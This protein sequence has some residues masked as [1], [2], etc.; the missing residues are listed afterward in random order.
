MHDSSEGE[1]HGSENHRRNRRGH[2]G[3]RHRLRRCVRRIP[4]DSR[5]HVA[6]HARAGLAYI[7]TSLDEGVT[8]GKVTAEQRDRALRATRFR[9][10]SWK[11]PAARRIWSSKPFPK[12]WKS[13]SK[14]SRCSINSRSR[15]DFRQSN[16]SSF[17]ITEMAA[18][19]CRPEKCIGLHFFNPVPKMKLLEVVRG[20]ETS[21]ETVA[22]CREV[23][24]PDGQRSCGGARS[25]R[26]HHQPHQR[27]DRQR[28]VLHARR[29]GS[30]PPPISIKRLKL[31]LNH[32]MGPFELVD[33]VGLDVRLRHSSNICT[34]RSAKN[35][36]RPAA[37]PIRKGGRLG[38]KS[39]R[40]VYDYSEQGLSGSRV[41]RTRTLRSS[42]VTEAADK[43]FSCTATS[44]RW[45]RTRSS[46][47]RTMTCSS[48][49]AS[50][51]P[52][53]R[54]GGDKFSANATRSVRFPWRRGD[55]FRRQAESAPR[56]S[57]SQHAAGAAPQRERAL[58]SSTAHS[59]AS[60]RKGPKTIAFPAVGTG[61]AGFPMREC[62]EIMLAEAQKHLQGATLSSK[63][64]LFSSTGD[65]SKYSSG[66]GKRQKRGKAK[67]RNAPTVC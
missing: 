29:R 65:P 23:G 46:T 19:T 1:S 53:G 55:H 59:F 18:I 44:P 66:C 4:H 41:S 42:V 43:I 11:K 24:A 22:A 63:Y 27:D 48:V 67:G 61:I 45:M 2:H 6:I 49:A 56:D 13:S 15:R 9:A 17:S 20:L 40:G 21:E 36:A 57:R 12:R 16:T 62:A 26:I 39:G 38:R 25:A 5:R 50:R 10:D 47:P 8:R 14:F 30:P 54:K 51:A 7:R 37:A 28:S 32:P 31:G 33:L 58:R 34:R 3:T 35:T 60:P 64:S 52:F